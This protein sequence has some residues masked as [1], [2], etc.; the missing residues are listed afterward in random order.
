MGWREVVAGEEIQRFGFQTEG[1]GKVEGFV[2]MPW[3][4]RVI[5]VLSG[6]M[7]VVV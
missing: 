4:L 6:R 1:E 3:M 5:S 2:C 7:M